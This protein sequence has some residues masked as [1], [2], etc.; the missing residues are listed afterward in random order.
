LPSVF[1]KLNAGA[2][3][4]ALSPLFSAIDLCSLKWCRTSVL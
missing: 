3:S 4:P 1:F 2:L